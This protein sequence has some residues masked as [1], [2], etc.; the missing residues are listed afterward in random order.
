MIDLLSKADQRYLIILETLWQQ[1]SQTLAL[2]AEKTG[3][4]KR[5]TQN[6]I[7]TINSFI[8]PLKIITSTKD[9]YSLFIPDTFSIDFIYSCILKNSVEFSFLEAV[10]FEN[11]S[12]LEDYAETLFVSVSTLKRMIHA[13]NESLSK[14]NIRITTSPIQL[15][16]DEKVISSTIFMLFSEKYDFDELPFS[17]IQQT[18]LTKL[19]DLVLKKDSH[20]YTFSD[21][22]MLKTICLI[23]II[24]IQNK[25]IQN[26]SEKLLDDYDVSFIN[27]FFIHHAFK[28]IFRIELNNQTLIRLLYPFISGTFAFDTDHLQKIAKKSDHNQKVVNHLDNFLE[29]ISREFKLPLVNKDQLILE[30]FNVYHFNYSE[31]YLIYNKKK[32]F[33]STF[34]ENAPYTSE[35]IYKGIQRASSLQDE[36]KSYEL[37]ELTY[38]FITHWKGFAHV[39]KSLEPQFSVG[40]FLNSD[41]EHAYFLKTMLNSIF[42]NE[43]NFHVI[44]GT[45]LEVVY[46]QTHEYSM[47]ITNVS[48]FKSKNTPHI[49]IGMYP[50]AND[51]QK[52]A[53]EYARLSSLL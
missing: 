53:A 6:D 19:I 46:K 37:E 34:L 35:L 23:A 12:R 39:I 21:I 17:T 33:L 30:L 38:I 8:S 2:L 26:Y 20:F 5:N 9:G 43:L 27:N 45:N 32:A 31:P 41:L 44:N 48:H 4:S 50:T 11:C 25:H 15:I 14:Y 16:G 42:Y 3:F 47:V 51:I 40:I 22:H 52:I 28:S 49:C 29:S 7:I 10:F 18:T 1:R 24:R 36:F 13:M